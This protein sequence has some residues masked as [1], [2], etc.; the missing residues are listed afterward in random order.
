MHSRSP[1]MALSLLPEPAPSIFNFRQSL[2]RWNLLN[3]VG[4]NL[5][6]KRGHRGP[7]EFG[8]C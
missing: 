8:A 6:V 4:A 2:L 1:P 7:S 5:W 3:S